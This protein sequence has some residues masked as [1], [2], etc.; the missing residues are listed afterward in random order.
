LKPIETPEIKIDFGIEKIRECMLNRFPWLYLDRVIDMQPG[1]F[2]KAIKNFTYNEHFFPTHFPGDP[3]V[4][5]F[6]QIECCMQSFLMTF[7]SLD[8]YKKRETADRLLNQVR[9]KRKIVPGDTLE[10][11]ATL[12]RFS[13]GVA[14]GRVESF[15]NSEP[16]ISFEVTA[17]V[18]DELDKFKPKSVEQSVI[19]PSAGTQPPLIE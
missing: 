4:P 3:S 13:H 15:V 7:L 19:P 12:D 5:G 16:A 14:K 1:K 8:Q 18:V 2:I 17:V 11:F 6:I 9:V 10:M